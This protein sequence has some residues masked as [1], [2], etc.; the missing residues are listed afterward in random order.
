MSVTAGGTLLPRGRERW[1]LASGRVKDVV[2]GGFWRR[3]G[4]EFE[5]RRHPLSADL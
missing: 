3:L 1:R 4:R 2:F 5:E